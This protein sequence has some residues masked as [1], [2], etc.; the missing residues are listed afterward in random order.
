MPPVVRALWKW[1]LVPLV[2]VVVGVV[3][4]VVPEVRRMLGSG[5]AWFWKAASGACLLFQGIMIL[6]LWASMRRIRL[7]VAASGGRTC[8][9]CLQ[10]LRGLGERGVCPEC[11]RVFSLEVDR[12]SW[13]RVKF[14]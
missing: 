11:G 8:T 14:V 1:L 5:S 3:A 2:F 6:G 13:R 10:D 12:A 4:I 9:A 7:A